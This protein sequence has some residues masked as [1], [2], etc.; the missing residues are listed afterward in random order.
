MV[1]D[2]VTSLSAFGRI[3]SDGGPSTQAWWKKSSAISVGVSSDG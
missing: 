2:A 3:D 1:M